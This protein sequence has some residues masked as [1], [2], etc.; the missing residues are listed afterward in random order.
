LLLPGPRKSVE[1][2][3]ARIAKRAAIAVESIIRPG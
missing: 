2:M 3:A 1:P